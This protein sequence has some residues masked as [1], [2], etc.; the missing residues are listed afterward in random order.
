MTCHLDHK[1]LSLAL[2]LFLPLAGARPS[3]GNQSQPI[4]V[5]LEL[6][7]NESMV[8]SIEPLLSDP[9][10]NSKLEIYDRLVYG[11]GRFL[12][13]DGKSRRNVVLALDAQGKYLVRLFDIPGLDA[14]TTSNKGNKY[15][16]GVC[17]RSEITDQVLLEFNNSGK[18]KLCGTDIPG[19]QWVVD[20]NTIV[21]N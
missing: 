1:I 18:T 10:T 14:R 2:S 8:R 5:A 19:D 3:W 15:F 16:G 12:R 7:L 20:V 6:E 17:S 21:I 11:K 4:G 9:Q 13:I